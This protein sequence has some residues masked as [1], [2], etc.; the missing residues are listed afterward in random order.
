[1]G[2]GR[3]EGAKAKAMTGLTQR[4]VGTLLPVNV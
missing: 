2:R 4:T 1:M 3:E